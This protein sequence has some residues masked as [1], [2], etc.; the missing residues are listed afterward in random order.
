MVGNIIIFLNI[1][2]SRLMT[3]RC[4]SMGHQSRNCNVKYIFV[5]L[6]LIFQDVQVQNERVHLPKEP[7]RI[8]YWTTF[9]RNKNMVFGFGQEPFIKAG[10][11]MTNCW[12]TA[13]RSDLNRSDALIFHVNVDFNET[14]LPEH[15]FQNQRYV[16][17]HLEAFPVGR[18]GQPSPGLNVTPHFYNWTMTHRR[19]SDVYIAWTYGGMKRK[20]GSEV[21]NWLPPP[22]P[23]VYI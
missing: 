8:L 16:M 19:D 23:K 1:F 9:Y 2:S 10:C 20:N 22:L 11:P 6:L 17:Y 7:K 12:A 13:D 5:I 21:L 18:S 3:W 14:D 4:P 15:R